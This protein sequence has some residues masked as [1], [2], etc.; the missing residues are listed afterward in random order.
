MADFGDVQEEV[1]FFA[2]IFSMVGGREHCYLQE[3]D[4]EEHALSS[5]KPNIAKVRQDSG[6]VWRCS[7]P[8]DLLATLTDATQMKVR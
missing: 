8:F 2:A 7:L 6:D 1:A 3:Q 5:S 4:V